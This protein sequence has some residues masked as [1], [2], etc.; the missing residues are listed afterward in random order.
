[1]QTAEFLY[2]VS[3]L[4]DLEY[5]LKHALTH[6][7]TY[8]SLLQDRRRTLDGRLVEALERLYPDR[9]AHHAFRGKLWDKAV[10]CLRQAGVK[11]FA[12]SAN[13]EAAAYFEQALTALTH[14]PETP[15]TLEQGI[16]VRLALRNSLW[17]LGRMETGLEH[18]RD[19]ERLAE[20]LGDQRR[21]GWIAAYLSEHARQTGHAADAPRFA[22]RA[23]VIAEGLGDLPLRVA[24][25]YYLGTA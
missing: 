15:E 12:R 23:Q 7:V 18:L 4:P 9:L 1:M 16:D 3:I 21:L 8:G 13:Q 25:S 17:P 11:A 10:I 19:A 5:T 14:L 2:E 24:A 20:V 6:D 22:E